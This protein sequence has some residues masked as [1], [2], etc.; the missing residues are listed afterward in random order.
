[1]LLLEKHNVAQEAEQLRVNK[2]REEEKMILNQLMMDAGNAM[3]GGETNWS[4][5]QPMPTISR[6][7]QQGMVPA[8]VVYPMQTQ[9]WVGE[10][11]MDCM[12]DEE[13]PCVIYYSRI[14]NSH[15][16]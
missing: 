9:P 5:G 13:S 1:M 14:Y 10:V 2:E 15:Y 12:E 16:L 7:Q 11:E 3:C 6:Q 8:K 4:G